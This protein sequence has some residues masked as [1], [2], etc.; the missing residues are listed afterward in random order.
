MHHYASS[1][2][3]AEPGDLGISISDAGG[4][5]RPAFCGPLNQ[6]V[7]GSGGGN[8]SYLTLIAWPESIKIS[9]QCKEE[10]KES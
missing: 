3:R 8:S 1:L 9:Q 5:S 10:G 7:R 6:H 4:S 2:M